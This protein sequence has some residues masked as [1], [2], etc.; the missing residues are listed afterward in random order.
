MQTENIVP[1]T[2]AS[3]SVEALSLRPAIQVVAIVAAVSI[4]N[5][6]IGFA[7]SIANQLIHF[8]QLVQPSIIG[9]L[10]GSLSDLA[11]NA[12]VLTYCVQS[13]R[14]SNPPLQRL[15]LWLRITGAAHILLSLVFGLA[16]F[17]LSFK[18]N[19]SEILVGFLERVAASCVSGAGY[20][21]AARV[22]AARQTVGCDS[23]HPPEASGAE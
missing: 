14:G 20:F 16:S 18:L 15:K 3:Q 19:R 22:I 8:K 7:A 23:S 13:L 1:L 17:V 12:V 2:Y 9:Y 5:T 21:L 11:C 6:T 4:V 10:F